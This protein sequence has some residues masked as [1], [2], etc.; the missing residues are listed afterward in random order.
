MLRQFIYMLEY[1]ENVTLTATDGSGDTVT[2][3]M[4]DLCN[5]V[6]LIVN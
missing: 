6:I 5:M 2:V 3:P 1:D 4:K